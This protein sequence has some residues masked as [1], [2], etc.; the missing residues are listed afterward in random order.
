MNRSR[1]LKNTKQ[2]EMQANRVL[3]MLFLALFILALV[4]LVS[5]SFFA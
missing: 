1:K 3:K 5:F 2:E 4:L